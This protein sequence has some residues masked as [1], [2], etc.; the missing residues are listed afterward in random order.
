MN[1][2]FAIQQDAAGI[3]ADAPVASD[4]SGS[5]GQSERGYRLRAGSEP[6]RIAHGAVR[7]Q[8][9][10]R[11]LAKVAARC[12]VGRSLAEQGVTHEVTPP[13]YSVKEAVF[14]VRQVPG[15]RHDPRTGDEVHR[16]GHGRRLH[17]RRSLREIAAGCGGEAA[18]FRHRLHLGQAP[19]PAQGGQGGAHAA[20]ARLQARRHQGHR[21]GAR[22]RRPA[23]DRRSTRSR[24]AGRTWSTCSRTAR[25]RW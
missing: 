12:M 16:R 4:A 2:Q 13:Y 9:D 22:R 23:G 20:R 3:A 14:P 11:A 10:R 7:V 21:V 8:G 1:V 24:K 15:R 5:S 19:R 6:A 17:L 25:S 18:D